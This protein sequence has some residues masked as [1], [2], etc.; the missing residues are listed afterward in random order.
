M[1][2]GVLIAL[3]TAALLMLSAGTALACDTGS[4]LMLGGN[5]VPGDMTP[6][7]G[8]GFDPG[9]LILVWD[10]SDG[11]VVG[12]GEATRDGRL[13][14]EVHIPA[15]AAGRH[16]IIALDVDDAGG[17]S[18]ADPH[19]WTD[20]VVGTLVAETLPTS[21]VASDLGQPAR[22]FIPAAVAF[23]I[24]VVAVAAVVMR[25]RRGHDD[26]G[27]LGELDPFVDGSPRCADHAVAPDTTQDDERGRVLVGR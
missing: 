8:G 5:P 9:R 13:E 10:H 12:T 4:W 18:P 23:G 14:T 22:G 17:D 7:R 21:A 6:L 1:K 26:A 20:V 11:E 15:D 19:A 2:R 25:G 3:C 27:G 24:L 16:K